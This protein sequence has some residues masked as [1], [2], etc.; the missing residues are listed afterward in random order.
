M[1]SI[2]NLSFSYTN[3][4]IIQNV[5]FKVN[6]GE[7]IAILGESGCG[8]S[9]LLKLIYGLLDSDQG[10]IFFNNLLHFSIFS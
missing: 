6:Q 10:E 8:K 1:L 5:S 2:Q 4:P 3:D 9:T 7:N